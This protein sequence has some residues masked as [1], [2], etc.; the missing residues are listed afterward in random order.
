MLGKIHSLLIAHSEKVS[1]AVH[2]LKSATE[3]WQRGERE[4]IVRLVE[5]LSGLEKEADSI[6]R[7]VAREISGSDNSYNQKE[8]FRRLAHQTDD[9]ADTARRAGRFL[10]IIQDLLLPPEIKSDIVKMASLSQAAMGRLAEAIFCLS[11]PAER[12]IE[13]IANI[14]QMEESV[15]DL[16]FKIQGEV[17]D[18]NV[19]TWSAIIFW[20]LVLTVGRIADF[21]EDA[22]DEL[23]A[24]E[25]EF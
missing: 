8:L 19:D 22:A 6:R 20:R 7:Q 2:T 13:H 14:S 18:L 16:E 5:E 1:L 11:E 23:L 4:E 15:D 3:A 17:A 21:I 25:G 10:L 9:V 12:R 24:Y